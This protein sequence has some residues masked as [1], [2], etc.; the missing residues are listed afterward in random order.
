MRL[1]EP[2]DDELFAAASMA[3]RLGGADRLLGRLEE[4]CYEHPEDP[5]AAFRYALALLAVLPTTGSEIRA[6]GRLSAVADALDQVV[7][8]V[9]GH[10][11]A[12]LLRIRIRCLLTVSRGML[13]AEEDAELGKA[14]S[15]ID[16][17]IDA[18]SRVG[19]QP[20]FS[21]AFLLAAHLAEWP[22]RPGQEL[23][24]GAELRARAQLGHGGPMPFR[25]LAALLGEPVVPGDKLAAEPDRG[26][27]A[28]RPEP[29]SGP[30]T[31]R[32]L[33]VETAT[34]LSRLMDCLRAHLRSFADLPDEFATASGTQA[35]LE[36][37][38][39]LAGGM[40]A[41]LRSWAAADADAAERHTGPAMG[42]RR[43]PDVLP[44]DG[45]HGR[46]PRHPERPRARLAASRDAGGPERRGAPDRPS[47]SVPEPGRSPDG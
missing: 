43:I 12:R 9:P 32:R 4:S 25:A 37:L 44:D 29:K 16:E 21:S 10:W 28:A 24:R 40:R 47:D 17:S 35:D 19:W 2:A 26:P 41:E 42:A 46:L 39:H 30:L 20:Y 13:Q 31:G 7:A 38:L 45:R 14:D 18:Q 23:R 33:L 11:L 15:E 36:D 22:G 6:Y 8:A 3:A 34:S 27:A 5:D 1:I